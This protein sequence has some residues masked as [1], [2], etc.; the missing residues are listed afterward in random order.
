MANLLFDPRSGRYRNRATG[1]FVPEADIRAVVD[2]VADGTSNLMSGLGER[3]R[4]GTLSLADFESEMMRL[5][6]LSHV[7]T[8]VM[9]SGGRDQMSP[10]RWGR[11]GR[12]IRDEYA[13]LRDFAG[14]IQDGTQPLDGRLDARARLYGQQARVQFETTRA[15]E[16]QNR[17]FTEERSVLGQAHHCRLCITEAGKGWQPIGTLIP[18]GS[19]T[20]LSNDRCTMRRRVAPQG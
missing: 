6:R 4:S 20:C 3:L 10:A 11:I 17:G 18:I 16:D 12:V 1:R 9:A 14:Q 2:A 5:I 8:G 7:G 13:R 15:A 19:R